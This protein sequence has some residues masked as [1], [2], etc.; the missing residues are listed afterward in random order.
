MNPPSVF[1]NKLFALYALGFAAAIAGLV[2]DIQR[3][4]VLF[5]FIGL[6]GSLVMTTL[7]LYRVARAMAFSPTAAR[8]ATEPARIPPDEECPAP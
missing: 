6:G 2:L 4:A 7:M 8:Q 5:G 3:G 1:S